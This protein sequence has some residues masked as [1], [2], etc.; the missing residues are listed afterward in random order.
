MPPPLPPIIL[1]LGPT[2]GGKT[3]LA[4]ELARRLPRFEPDSGRWRLAPEMPSDSQPHLA[5]EVISA[6]SMQVYRGMD[7][8]TAKPDATEQAG[9]PH[10]LLDCVDPD[11]AF[12]ASDWLQQA[13][14]AID[15]VRA[16]GCW[17][18]VVGGTNLYV[19]LL[20]EGMFEGPPADEIL[21]AELAERPAPELHRRLASFDP[22]A[23]DRIHPNDRK[24]LTRAIEVYA[25][26]GRPI[27]DWQREWDAAAG[28]ESDGDSPGTRRGRPDALVVGLEWSPEAINRRI[29]ARV[30]QMVE[31]GLVD[32]VRALHEARRLGPQAREALG[33]KQ[34]LESLE[35]RMSGEEAIERVKIETRRFARKQR[36]WLKQF[37]RYPRSLWL[38]AESRTPS[39][40]ADE[41]VRFCLGH[42]GAG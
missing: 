33:Y 17:P 18:L 12:T 28:I 1:L 32:E 2:A 8:G 37:R 30:R 3:A 9:V 23:A 10:H 39:E 6:D 26:T 27:S 31:R 4:I 22:E 13:E 16:R 42:T 41:V 7:I 29:N 34:V 36:T 35:G 19:R 24:R 38:D 20:M 40:L 21:R 14:A 15:A 5:G 11:V 25:Q